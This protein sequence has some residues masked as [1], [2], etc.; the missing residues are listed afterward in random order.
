MKKT[1]LPSRLYLGLL[2]LAGSFGIMSAQ[3]TYYVA[4]GGSDANACINSGSPCLTIG[5]A[6]S[7]APLAGGVTISIA[8][9]SYS[10]TSPIIVNKPN[11]TFNGAGISSTTI[12]IN[13]AND[14]AFRQTSNGITISN[15]TLTSAA[16]TLNAGI[17]VSGA[18]SG[19]TVEN[20]ELNKLGTPTGASNGSNGSGIRILNSFSTLSVKNSKFISAH[21]GVQSGSSGIACV[22]ATGTGLSNITVQGCTFQKLFIGFWSQVPV[23][24]L[25][26][27]GNT[28]DFEVEDGYSG[29]AGVYIGDLNG[30]IKDVRV[31]GN[32]FNA[33]TRGVYIFNY[34]TSADASSKVENVQISDNSFVN[35]VWSSAIRLITQNNSTMEGI[36]IEGNFISQASNS[37]TKSL[38]FIDLRQGKA[39][40]TPADDNIKIV[41]NCITY[42]SGGSFSESTWG[43]LLRGRG[44]GAVQIL[45]N[46]IQG[47]SVG[48][49]S[50]PEL[51]AYPIPPTSGIVV[52]TQFEGTGISSDF[53]SMSAG[54]EISIANNYINGF[55]VANGYGLLFYKRD[56]TGAVGGIPAGARIFVQENHFEDNF[57]AIATGTVPDNVVSGKSNWYGSNVLGVVAG[58]IDLGT[59]TIFYTPV[60]QEGFEDGDTNDPNCGDGFQ[61][62]GACCCGN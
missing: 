59:S 23:D 8:A 31:S 44:I 18:T 51:D 16:P 9:G 58:R 60:L 43:I 13:N 38:A 50:S 17:E 40:A 12:S 56:N 2:F 62:K 6:L 7:K 32:T 28:F 3:T 26:V 20:V 22:G 33:Y 4:P 34:S 41:R 37:F 46:S 5:A 27:T 24:V 15:L 42:S 35:S 45:N 39:P 48:G 52:Q 10:V 1:L 55:D 47:N 61:P 25:R 49:Q 19:L 53:G 21:Q 29:S 11:I 36:R 30:A 54:A 14:P 57:K